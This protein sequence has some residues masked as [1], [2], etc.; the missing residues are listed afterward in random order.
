M[1]PM[2]I[3]KA[4]KTL[5]KERNIPNSEK[6]NEIPILDLDE[7]DSTIKKIDFLKDRPPEFQFLLHLGRYSFKS[8]IEPD[9]F[10]PSDLFIPRPEFRLVD[11]TSLLAM[12]QERDKG[13]IDNWGIL[14]G[15]KKKFRQYFTTGILE[16]LEKEGLITLIKGKG[17]SGWT[18]VFLTVIGWFTAVR[19]EFVT[20]VHRSCMKETLLTSNL[21][22]H[23]FQEDDD[24]IGRKLLAWL[25]GHELKFFNSLM[26][27]NRDIPVVLLSASN[28]GS[29]KFLQELQHQT[30]NSLFFYVDISRLCEPVNQSLKDILVSSVDKSLLPLDL[31]EKVY[32]EI[33]ENKQI[34]NLKSWF[35]HIL[36]K[37]KRTVEGQVVILLDHADLFFEQPSAFSSDVAE[38][39][40]YLSEK[41]TG[42]TTVFC[43][44][45]L[46]NT[47]L[48]HSYVYQFPPISLEQFNEILQWE[49]KRHV[50]SQIASS[51]RFEKYLFPSHLSQ[52][53]YKLEA[54]LGS[55]FPMNSLIYYASK[56]ASYSGPIETSHLRLGFIIGQVE[57]EREIETL[58][59]FSLLQHIHEAY[60]EWSLRNGLK[61]PSSRSIYRFWIEI[62]SNFKLIF[63]Q[64][65]ERWDSI[66]VFLTKENNFLRVNSDFNLN[67][68][69]KCLVGMQLSPEEDL[70]NKSLE[71]FHHVFQVWEDTL[72][73]HELPSREMLETF[74]TNLDKLL[75]HPT[76]LRNLNLGHLT[77]GLAFAILQGIQPN[78]LVL[79]TV[80]PYLKDYLMRT[81]SLLQSA[82]MPVHEKKQLLQSFS[83]NLFT[84]TQK[85]Q[86]LKAKAGSIVECY[87]YLPPTFAVELF[88]QTLTWTYS[89]REKMSSLI[90]FLLAQGSSL[91]E[92]LSTDLNLSIPFKA[93]LGVE[94]DNIKDDFLIMLIIRFF[95]LYHNEMLFLR[96]L[97]DIFQGF[98]RIDEEHL[99]AFEH[100]MAARAPIL[101]PLFELVYPCNS[102][103]KLYGYNEFFLIPLYLISFSKSASEIKTALQDSPPKLD[104][105]NSLFQT[106]L[107][108]YLSIRDQNYGGFLLSDLENTIYPTLALRNFLENKIIGLLLIG[109]YAYSFDMPVQDLWKLKIGG[110]PYRQV[111]LEQIRS[112]WKA[113]E[114]GYSRLAQFIRKLYIEYLGTKGMEE[115]V[116]EFHDFLINTTYDLKFYQN[117]EGLAINV[118]VPYSVPE[119]LN[120]CSIL[121]DHLRNWQPTTVIGALGIIIGTMYHFE[122]FEREIYGLL[123]GDRSPKPLIQ[124]LVYFKAP[125]IDACTKID[126]PFP[127]TTGNLSDFIFLLSLHGSIIENEE[128]EQV[129]KFLPS[130]KRIFEFGQNL[131]RKEVNSVQPLNLLTSNLKLI[132][133]GKIL[134]TLP[135]D[136]FIN[137][138]S[139]R[140]EA[141]NLIELVDSMWNEKGIPSGFLVAF[142]YRLLDA[143]VF[144]LLRKQ[145]PA[146]ISLLTILTHGFSAWQVSDP[147]PIV[148]SM[149][150]ALEGE[151][152]T[153]FNQLII[154]TFHK[155]FISAQKHFS[156]LTDQDKVKVTKFLNEHEWFVRDLFSQFLTN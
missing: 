117:A 102:A 68:I 108:A 98:I 6:W 20:K 35:D 13:V 52:Y 4:R 128:F 121:A 101:V 2:D 124:E 18:M 90:D 3:T 107:D 54:E 118:I 150:T 42:Y 26:T 37:I 81:L 138:F 96:F 51:D 53:L 40:Q 59:V 32:S 64:A 12:H 122:E 48:V 89:S 15:S 82:E 106:I 31:K 41:K 152:H 143:L 63:D 62:D 136:K 79:E 43:L 19:L 103:K 83:M 23:F 154:R 74:L 16:N 36:E 110:K 71:E 123:E 65:S 144:S 45:Q 155:S 140:G 84:A 25:R 125:F 88:K 104:S 17:S 109:E 78:E 145:E 39:L 61:F 153:K 151:D 47:P 70:F 126:Y 130:S 113:S 127:Q 10:I 119:M 56:L 85:S 115:R 24:H 77:E 95:N 87:F 29:S 11:R 134:F 156:Q 141:I 91:V 105:K 76:K 129:S 133:L 57:L 75:E 27:E 100:M 21:F 8:A 99:K 44:K 50:I 94:V 33:V 7:L 49:R 46:S 1:M 86:T 112:A 139:K 132:V 73:L 55:T 72:I 34:E 120:F 135:L 66:N 14:F 92:F 69:T 149:F 93:S 58:P 28:D 146:S 9:K 30:K 80:S 111:L 5:R 114:T 137:F 147:T 38:L 60:S 148:K 97:D 22:G 67:L 131:K 116:N 142:Y